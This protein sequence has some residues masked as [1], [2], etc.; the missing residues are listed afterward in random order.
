MES[1]MRS[2]YTPNFLSNTKGTQRY[3]LNRKQKPFQEIETEHL[4]SINSKS[5]IQF[6]HNLS[7]NSV[8]P[9]WATD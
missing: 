2:M 4:P 8:N 1:T 3:K 6:F 7:F 9:C 5:V